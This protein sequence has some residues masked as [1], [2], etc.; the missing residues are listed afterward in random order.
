[1]SAEG[2]NGLSLV[3]APEARR[4]AHDRAADFSLTFPPEL[5]DALADRLAPRVAALLREAADTD[6]WFDSVRAADYLGMTKNALHKLTSAREIPFEQDAPG[7]K[8]YFRRS[9][10]DRWRAGGKPPK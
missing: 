2:R 1:M 5:L 7:H 10:L 3:P 4:P 9:A 6:G 8:L